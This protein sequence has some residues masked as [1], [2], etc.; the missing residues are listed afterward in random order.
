MI[1]LRRNARIAGLVAC[2]GSSVA[3]PSARAEVHFSILM[4]SD[5]KQ[6][7]LTQTDSNPAARFSTDYA[8]PSG[9]FAGGF[10][11]N[12]EY[13]WDE[14]L[15]SQRDILTSLYVGHQWR[16]QKWTS[17]VSI[18]RYIYPDYRPNYNY[19]QTAVSASYKS[20]YF[21]SAARIADYPFMNQ[22]SDQIRG[23]VTLPW[24]WGLEASINAGEL[25]SEG[26]FDFS[27]T[28]WDTGLS[29][30]FGRFALDLRY[31]DDN[32]DRVGVAGASGN[33]RWVLSIGYALNPRGRVTGS[34]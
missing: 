5:Y 27:Y 10:V 31:H 3:L 23:G 34:D 6:Y 18:S 16:G 17:A 7:G 1:R 19:T 8:H 4:A 20:R 22:D 25:R 28:F 26:V 21:L 24:L 32:Y 29:K 30:V 11:S 33:D 12:A 9:L 15:E 13:A 14:S 2:I